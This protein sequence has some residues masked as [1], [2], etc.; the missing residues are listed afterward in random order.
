MGNVERL[1]IMDGAGAG[2]L[3]RLW[4]PAQQVEN[5]DVGYDGRV[6]AVICEHFGVCGGLPVADVAVPRSTRAR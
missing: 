4:V 2:D 3:H 1:L 6:M 5:R